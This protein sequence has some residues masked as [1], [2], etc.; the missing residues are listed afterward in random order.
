MSC[1]KTLFILIILLLLQYLA[2]SQITDFELLNKHNTINNKFA[3]KKIEKKANEANTLSKII[4][5]FP[6]FLFHI[7][8]NSLLLP[9]F[10]KSNF[11]Y[12][13]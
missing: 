2:Y 7:Y 3:I 10:L 1:I 4:K 12:I 5:I 11:F 13:R 8:K 6:G 9:V